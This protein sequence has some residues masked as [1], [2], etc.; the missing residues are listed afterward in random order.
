MWALC[1]GILASTLPLS[2]CIRLSP[3]H[4]FRRVHNAQSTPFSDDASPVEGPLGGV[5]VGGRGL[6]HRHTAVHTDLLLTCRARY[7]H[8]NSC[9]HRFA[10]TQRPAPFIL[11]SQAH[12]PQRHLPHEVLLCFACTLLPCNINTLFPA[13]FIPIYVSADSGEDPESQPQ[14]ILRAVFYQT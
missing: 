5:P 8:M 4:C 1:T 7:A 9:T 13:L 11:Y 3:R 12:T 2:K 6:S 14:T 10:P